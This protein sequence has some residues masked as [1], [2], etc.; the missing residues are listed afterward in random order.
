M[1][2]SVLTDETVGEIHSAINARRI[3]CVLPLA[4]SR[5]FSERRQQE[6]GELARIGWPLL[7]LMVALI[8]T[9]LWV[10]FHESFVGPDAVVWWWLVTVTVGTVA[11][12]VIAAQFSQVHECYIPVVTGIGM[13][14]AATMV[15]GG[16]LFRNP[17]VAQEANYISILVVIVIMLP[18]KLPLLAGATSC[19]GGLVIGALVA[20]QL[21]AHPPWQLVLTY[22]PGSIIIVF[23]IG[24]LIQRQERINFLQGLLLTHESAER[25]RL[26][27]MLERLALEDQLTGLANRRRFN[28]ALHHEW[29][30]CQRAQQPLALLFIDV[31]YFKHYNDSYGHAAGDQCLSSI[32]RATKGSLLRPADLA[33]RYGGEEFVILLPETTREGA[34]EVAQRV[35]AHIDALDIPHKSSEVA[36]HVTVSIGIALQVPDRYSSAPLL[37]ENADKALYTAKHAGRHQAV[38]YTE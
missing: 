14:V 37:L 17:L 6:F 26:N 4:V 35:L 2:T 23:F 24:M 10:Q 32:G 3:W 38:M 29:E 36:P 34:M 13:I 25:M 18:L 5:Q 8:I 15:A 16:M 31:D 19:L 28:D 7:A 30:R 12:G 27:A 20:T 21:G 22:Y 1:T 11:V 33:A 9:V